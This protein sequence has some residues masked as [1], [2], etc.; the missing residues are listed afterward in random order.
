M[1][2]TNTQAE[3]NPSERQD[4]KVANILE[5]K[6]QEAIREQHTSTPTV[7]SAPVTP[8]DAAKVP[9]TTEKKSLNIGQGENANGEKQS[10]EIFPEGKFEVQGHTKITREAGDSDTGK[11][12][13]ADVVQQGGGG[14][15]DAKSI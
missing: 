11:P 1:A 5:A 12:S 10:K 8:A 13:P 7:Q 2:D 14:A 6:R 4:A 3:R 15:V 9:E